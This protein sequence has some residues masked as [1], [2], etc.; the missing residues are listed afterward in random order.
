LK[1]FTKDGTDVV[2]TSASELRAAA[3]LED[4]DGRVALAVNFLESGFHVSI[5]RMPEKAVRRVLERTLVSEVRVHPSDK[6]LDS[7]SQGQ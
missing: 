7:W 5:E 1:A 6:G 4:H 2:E 3:R